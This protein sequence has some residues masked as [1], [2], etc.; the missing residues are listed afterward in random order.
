[1]LETSQRLT[2]AAETRQNELGVHTG[3]DQ[4]DGNTRLVLIVVTLREEH[5]SHTTAAQLANQAIRTNPPSFISRQL[6]LMKREDGVLDF[7]LNK[8]AGRG[9]VTGSSDIT[10]LR[11]S[12]SP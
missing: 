9:L 8:A 3:T 5:G 4:F 1:M 12:S 6:R 11:R 2:F 10:S 7:F